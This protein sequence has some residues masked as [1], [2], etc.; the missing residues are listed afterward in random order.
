[1]MELMQKYIKEDG[2][3]GIDDLDRWHSNSDAV[4]F[5][6]ATTS[7]MSTEELF[8]VY[9]TLLCNGHSLTDLASTDEPLA[10]EG[11]PYRG[12]SHWSD[13]FGTSL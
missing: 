3:I 12:I 4:A 2:A 13:I 5:L 1:M 7:A 6:S 11:G 10:S 9:T 8:R